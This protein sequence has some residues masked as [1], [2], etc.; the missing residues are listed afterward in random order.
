MTFLHFAAVHDLYFRQN[1]RRF[2]CIALVRRG[3]FAGRRVTN[4]MSVRNV[5]R[6]LLVETA[7]S[8][9]PTSALM[10]CAVILGDRL[11]RRLIRLAV[12]ADIALGLPDLDTV[13]SPCPVMD[14]LRVRLTAC[15]NT[16]N[17]CM[18]FL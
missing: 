11:T 2:S 3:F 8:G 17:F 9:P 12:L 15:L 1:E 18:M 6:M 5:L 13:A 10:D 4:P 14:R 7:A 16:D